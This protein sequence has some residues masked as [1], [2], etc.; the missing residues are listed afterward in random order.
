MK[1]YDS[2]LVPLKLVRLPKK[3]EEGKVFVAEP[4]DEPA[5]GCRVL[6]KLHQILLAPGWLHEPD[7]I[8]LGRVG[9]EA[10]TAHNEAE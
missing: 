8:D 7:S 5:Q 3:F 10:S 6:C 9:F 1:G 4:A 2:F